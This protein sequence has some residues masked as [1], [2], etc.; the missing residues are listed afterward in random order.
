MSFCAHCGPAGSEAE[1]NRERADKDTEKEEKLQMKAL[2]TAR[3]RATGGR[4][5]HVRSDDGI[6]KFDLAMPKELGGPGGQ[7]TNP[8]QLFA[9]GYAAC[10]ANALKRVAREQRV[11]WAAPKVEAEVGIGRLE[12]SR[13]GLTVTLKIHSGKLEQEMAEKLIADAHAI[14]PYSNAVRGNID[15]D[16]QL[17]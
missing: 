11:D 5:G 10:F 3:A 2:Y 8:E 12:N 9:A 13:F 14:C 7:A 16:L 15:V 4:D 6:L 1:L 17:V